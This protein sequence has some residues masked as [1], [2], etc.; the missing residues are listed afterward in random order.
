MNKYFRIGKKIIVFYIIQNLLFIFQEQFLMKFP[1]YDIYKKLNN[2][3]VTD[4]Y[5]K[6]CKIMKSS[7]PQN[8]KI[9]ELCRIFARNLKELSTILN[10]VNNIDL[11][12]YFNFWKYD[13]INKN[14]DTSNNAYSIDR[15]RI[16]FFSVASTI[17]EESPNHDCFYPYRREISLDSWK[18]WKDLYDY[19]RNKDKI[20]KII[21]SDVY[22]CS[23]Y[24]KYFSYIKNIYQKYKEVC[25]PVANGNCPPYINFSEWCSQENVLIQLECTEPPKLHESSAESTED[26]AAK[27]KERD[28]GEKDLIT[29]E[30]E[31]DTNA[32]LKDGLVKQAIGPN[33]TRLESVTQDDHTDSENSEEISNY[34]IS[35]STGTIIGTSL[36]FVLPLITIYRVKTTYFMHFHYVCSFKLNYHEKLLK[37]NNYAFKFDFC[38]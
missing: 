28:R 32:E 38:F 29:V 6:Y 15:I 22:L 9:Y 8:P 35:N 17:K 37:M 13:Q 20:P 19:I 16:S 14:H 30:G 34:N 24:S 18:E 5:D 2:N 7:F 33:G 3:D 21:E 26:I 36:G 31:T 1:S 25:C 4:E 11:C 12:R 23:I 27:L 10:D